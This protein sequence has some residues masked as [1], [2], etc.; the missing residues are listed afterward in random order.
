MTQTL[1][2]LTTMLMFNLLLSGCQPIAAPVE[3]SSQRVNLSLTGALVNSISVLDLASGKQPPDLPATLIQVTGKGRPTSATITGLSYAIPSEGMANC[4]Q[5]AVAELHIVENP[6]VIT[7]NDGSLLNANSSA[8]GGT[9][10]L[11]ADGSSTAQIS[12]QI[13]GGSGKYINASGSLE[14]AVKTYPVGRSLLAEEGT[15]VGDIILQPAASAAQKSITNAKI[16]RYAS[17]QT[18]DNRAL[19][20]RDIKNH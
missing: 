5:S 20:Y 15:L 2:L 13:S 8:E 7:F 12:L 10:C 16:V 3:S 17:G 14:L 11:S 9:I 6:I 4:E 18:I 1:R 19:A